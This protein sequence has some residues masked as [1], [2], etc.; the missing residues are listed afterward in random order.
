MLLPE[1]VT[2]DGGPVTYDTETGQTNILYR[3]RFHNSKAVTPEEVQAIA[4]ELDPFETQVD[5]MRRDIFYQECGFTVT[6]NVLGEGGCER[7]VYGMIAGPPPDQTS[8]D[9]QEKAVEMH[10]AQTTILPSEKVET[11]LSL[12]EKRR[13]LRRAD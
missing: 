5:R 9:W 6:R 7:I 8:E 3:K 12:R 13:G 4:D 11:D 10:K 1:P 2:V